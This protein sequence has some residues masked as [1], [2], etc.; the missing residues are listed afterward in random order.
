MMV[1]IADHDVYRYMN[2]VGM[3]TIPVQLVMMVGV[4][5]LDVLL[6]AVE[7]GLAGQKLGKDTTDGPDVDGLNNQ[8]VKPP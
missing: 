2:T 1:S 4:A 3:G 5:G 8:K 7:D 6:T